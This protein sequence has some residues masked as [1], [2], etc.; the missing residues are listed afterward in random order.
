MANV[1]W[2]I[3]GVIYSAP[4]AAQLAMLRDG[5]YALLTPPPSKADQF[6]LHWGAAIIYLMY[7]ASVEAHPIC[8]AR[9]L[10]HEE[11]RRRIPAD[12]RRE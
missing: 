10:A 2:M 8:V 6:S 7:H 11:R 1:R 3:G 12:K 5:D 4:M 9:E